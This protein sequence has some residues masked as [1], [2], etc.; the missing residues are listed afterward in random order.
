MIP[1]EPEPHG[2]GAADP[3]AGLGDH[4]SAAPANDVAVGL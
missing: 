1:P 2:P 3:V 4:Q